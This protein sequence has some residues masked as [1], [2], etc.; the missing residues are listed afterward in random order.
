MAFIIASISI[1]LSLLL[2]RSPV[3]FSFLI[4]CTK[5]VFSPWSFFSFSKSSEISQWCTSIIV[6]CFNHLTG[7]NPLLVYWDTVGGVV[8]CGEEVAFC[9]L[10]IKPHCFCRL[11]FLGCDLHKCFS[12][13]TAPFSGYSE[14]E[15]KVA[16][17]CL[18]L[19]DPMNCS[20]PG[21]SV[22]GIL[23]A[24]IVEW[25]AMPFSRGFSWPRDQ[26]SL[27]HL[28]HWQAGSLLVPLMPPGK[29]GLV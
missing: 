27:L 19:C 8:R 25:V 1:I 23:Q 21:S 26:T 2:L 11:V 7:Y 13:L 24:R 12:L 18:T 17:S 10:Q 20:L 4:L 6:F 28:L 15:V 9:N 5:P 29:P 14:S 22:H 16:Q 3:V